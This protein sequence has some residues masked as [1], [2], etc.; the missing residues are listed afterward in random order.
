MSYTDDAVSMTTEAMDKYRADDQGEVGA[1][2]VVVGLSADRA[3]KEKRIRDDMI[4]VAHR[5][6]ASIRQLAD[7]SGLNRKT[8]MNIVGTQSGL[9]DG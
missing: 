5:A 2:L 4:V 9:S 3:A 1:A 7:T 6:G 8:I